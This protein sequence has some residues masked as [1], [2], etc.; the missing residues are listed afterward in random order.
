MLKTLFPKMSSHRRTPGG[1][2][3]C[4][5]SPRALHDGDADARAG[6]AEGQSEPAP[7]EAPGRK[8]GREINESI[9]QCTTAALQV[10]SGP[11]TAVMELLKTQQQK[12]LLRERSGNPSRSRRHRAG[13][14]RP[15]LT[16][17]D[18]SSKCPHPPPAAPAAISH[19]CQSRPRAAL[20]RLPSEPHGPLTRLHLVRRRRL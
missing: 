19:R 13:V 17:A 2:Q 14:R 10:R 11:A 9:Q 8:L 12:Q 1:Q 4:A 20:S 16:P 18:Q 6:A 15:H 5:R 7:W 3:G